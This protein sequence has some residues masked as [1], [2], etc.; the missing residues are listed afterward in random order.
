MNYM[1]IEDFKI[2]VSEEQS[3]IVQEVLFKNGYKWC[4][5]T[6]EV[7]CLDKPYLILDLKGDGGLRWADNNFVEEDFPE[8][9]FEEF[10]EKYMKEEK[11]LRYNEGKP[12]WSYVHFQSLLPM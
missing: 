12:K 8:L 4:D 2:K 3:R 9:T 7:C 11:A 10:K 1:N 6:T 5:D